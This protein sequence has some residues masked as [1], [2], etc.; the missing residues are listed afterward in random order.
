VVDI[1]LY[2]LK[3]GDAA[4]DI[5]DHTL[6]E[7]GADGGQLGSYTAAKQAMLDAIARGYGVNADNNWVGGPGRP[8]H[9]VQESSKALLQAIA[10][11]LDELIQAKT[12]F[13]NSFTAYIDHI[14]GVAQGVQSADDAASTAFNNIMKKMDGGQ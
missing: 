14:A 6:D 7:W 13:V 8:G 4:T 11:K 12:S 2:P 1:H 3:I 5:R 9:Q 10:G